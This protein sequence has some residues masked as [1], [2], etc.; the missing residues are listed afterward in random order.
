MKPW[1]AILAT[2]LSL[3][4]GAYIYFVERPKM[5]AEAAPDKLLNFA[6][7]DVDTIRLSYPDAEPILIRRKAGKW[8]IEAPLEYPAE[9]RTV[10]N[11]VKAA[12]DLELQRRL[13]AGETLELSSYG[14]E[15]DGTQARIQFGLK[16]GQELPAII[17]GRTTPVGFS[18]FARLEDSD[19]VVVTPLLFHSGVKKTL[20]DLRD[21]SLFDI[22]FDKALSLNLR[23]KDRE[24]RFQRNG[25]T[26]NMVAPIR[27]LADSSGL[28]S[29]VS[30]INAL[31][32][33]AFVDPGTDG[34]EPDLAELG[35]DKPVLEVTVELKGGE[36]RGFAMSDVAEEQPSGHY[37][38]RLGDGQIAKVANSSVRIFTKDPNEMRDKSVFRCDFDTVKE[39]RFRPSSSTAF[40]LREDSDGN[41]SIDP[42]QQRKLKQAAPLRVRSGLARLQA[43][44]IVSDEGNEAEAL[45]RFGLYRPLVEVSVADSE[46]N[47]CAA[48]SAGSPDPGAEQPVYYFKRAGSPTIM[49][50]GGH[51]FSRLDFK[52]DDFL[53][54][55]PQATA[56]K[57]DPSSGAASAK[58]QS[59]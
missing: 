14:L 11:L 1:K 8:Q 50:G 37:L 42:P 58:T 26:W 59:D 46:G 16:D 43:E 25:D 29:L 33:M 3:I 4:F 7:E 18:A 57:T 20:F 6:A 19:E 44:H 55:A 10:N 9:Q 39:L 40:V 23:G 47:V 35:L 13:D 51:L 31:R 49:S 30:S 28:R 21:K 48:A 34:Y 17:V 2:A 56:A 12:A 24:V 45:K 27:D 36:R 5:E 53:E 15:G 54:A 41:W 32:A 22:D 38:R 52:P